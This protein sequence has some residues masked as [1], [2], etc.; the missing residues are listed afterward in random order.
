MRLYAKTCSA[1][2]E[3]IDG[4]CLTALKKPWHPDCFRCSDCGK[5]LKNGKYGQTENCAPVCFNCSSSSGIGG[6]KGRTAGPS[7]TIPGKTEDS[8]A[9]AK[10]KP[11]P[12]AHHF[13][14]EGVATLEAVSSSSGTSSRSKER[15]V[16]VPKSEGPKAPGLSSAAIGAISGNRH[17]MSGGKTVVK[18][19]VK[20]SFGVAKNTIDTVGLGYGDL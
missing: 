15:A 9:K 7:S 12:F 17:M 4:T 16:G 2:H 18:A 20:P 6:A 13:G 8:K 1:C 10:P 5:D 11:M 3:K 14:S 19:K